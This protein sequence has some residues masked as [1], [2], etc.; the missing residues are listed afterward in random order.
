MLEEESSSEV[1]EEESLEEVHA[2]KRNR[3]SRMD[4]DKSTEIVCSRTLLDGKK[5]DGIIPPV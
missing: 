2:T 1:L 5:D 3:I 4:S